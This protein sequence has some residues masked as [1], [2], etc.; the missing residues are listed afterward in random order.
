MWGRSWKW[1]IS[2]GLVLALAPVSPEDGKAVASKGIAALAAAARDPMSLFSARSPGSRGNG[3]T[4]QTKPGHAA[5]PLAKRPTEKVLSE[6]RER[7]QPMAAADPTQLARSVPNVFQ[8]P[9]ASAPTPGILPVDIPT[10]TPG[11]GP[12]PIPV[13]PGGG[14]GGGGVIPSPAPVA[15]PTPEPTAVPEPST[16]AMLIVG[17]G[18]IGSAM[19]RRSNAQPTIGGKRRPHHART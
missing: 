13:I 2:A 7:P 18:L 19:R 17:I 12:I 4:Y 6:A 14:P 15:T 11:G 9:A 8:P 5:A 16:W 10:G 3:A 1:L